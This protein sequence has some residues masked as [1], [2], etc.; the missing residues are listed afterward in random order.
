[1][2]NLGLEDNCF[3][4]EKNMLRRIKEL[5]G[6]GQPNWCQKKE[7][8]ALPLGNFHEKERG[9]AL[10]GKG[11]KKHIVPLQEKAVL[12]KSKEHGG[13]VRKQKGK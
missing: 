9:R 6:D 11:F 1:V 12:N 7:K 4:A 2:I 3:G 8:K 10:R 5:L 13:L